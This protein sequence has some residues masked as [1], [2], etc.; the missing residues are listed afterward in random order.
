[1]NSVNLTGRITKDPE[2]KYSPNNNAYVMFT[3]AVD[4]GYKD[5]DGNKQSDFI[6]CVAWYNQA[7]FISKYVKKGNMLEVSG[8]IQVRN[9]KLDNGE[10]RTMVEIVVD[11]V[12]NLTPRPKEEKPAPQEPNTFNPQ[13][14]TPQNQNQEISMVDDED[15][16]F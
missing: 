16:P 9:Y 2:L 11:S 3:L 5:K 12:S 4:R 15:L 1:M 7:D 13:Y 8:S 6:S 14:Q 10:N